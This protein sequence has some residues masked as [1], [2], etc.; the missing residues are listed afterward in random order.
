MAT[1]QVKFFSVKV[2]ENLLFLLLVD[3]FSRKKE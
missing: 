1:M 2:F 3:W